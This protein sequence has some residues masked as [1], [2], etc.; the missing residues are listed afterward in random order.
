MLK[1]P[2]ALVGSLPACDLV[3]PGV[4]P[5]RAAVWLR[6]DGYLELAEIDVSVLPLGQPVMSARLLRDGEEVDLG[7]GEMLWIEQPR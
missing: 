5:I 1:V 3:V 7:D 6:G 2:L 4:A